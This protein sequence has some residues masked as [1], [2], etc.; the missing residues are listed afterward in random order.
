MSSRGGRGGR[1]RGCSIQFLR[2]LGW[3]RCHHLIHALTGTRGL[4]GHRD[5]KRERRRLSCLHLS[6]SALGVASPLLT[7]P[8]PELTTRAS[9]TIEGL[10]VWFCRGP[11]EQSWRRGGTRHLHT[12]CLLCPWF[13]HGFEAKLSLEISC[14]SPVEGAGWK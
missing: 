7:A 1:W 3:Q 8:W 11:E 10:E 13:S 5:R 12:S 14:S 2:D 4:L 9:L 6:T